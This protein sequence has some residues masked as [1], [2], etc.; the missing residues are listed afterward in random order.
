MV[1]E[2]DGLAN[3]AG[4]L[5]PGVEDLAP[6]IGTVATIDASAS[7]IDDQVRAFQRFRPGPRIYGIPR[8]SSPV[9]WLDPAG[10][11]CNFV[12]PGMEV[13]CERLAYLPAT[14]WNDNAQWMCQ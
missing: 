6:V 3:E 12:T 11:G 4:R 1:E 13:P 10:N 7:Q 9:T 5:N 14:A 2:G 8:K